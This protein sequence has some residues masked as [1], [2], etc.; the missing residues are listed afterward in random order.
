M[1]AAAEEKDDQE[2]RKAFERE[3]EKHA[4]PAVA[5][6]F[7]IRPQNRSK[8]DQNSGLSS[9]SMKFCK[10]LADLNLNAWLCISQRNHP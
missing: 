1:N 8:F 6:H 7:A 9:K 2:I 3:R 5:E 4:N 10:R